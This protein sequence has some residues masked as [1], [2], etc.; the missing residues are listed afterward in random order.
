MWIPKLIAL[1]HSLDSSLDGNGCPHLFL[2]L[3]YVQEDR[4]RS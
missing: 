2:D 1:M 3:E 4:L